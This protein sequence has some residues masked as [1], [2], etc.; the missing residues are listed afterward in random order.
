MAKEIVTL[1]IEDTCL[2]LMVV[3]DK[4]VRLAVSQPLEAG[5][6]KNGTVVDRQKLSQAIGD[7]FQSHG[8]ANGKVVMAISGINAFYRLISQPPVPSDMLAEAAKREA[9]R[10]MPVPLSE[11]HLSYQVLSSSKIES[12]LGL[13]GLPR[14]PT[15]AQVETLRM[16]GLNPYVMDI[17]PLALVRAVSEPEAIFIEVQEATFDIVLTVDGLPQIIRSLSFPRSSLPWPEKVTAITEELDR[18]VKFYNSAHKDRPLKTTVALFVSGEID[19]QGEEL[20]RQRLGYESRALPEPPF[21]VD[22]LDLRRYLVNLGLALKVADR[23]NHG[24]VNINVLPEKYLPKKRPLAQ[25]LAVA[26]LPLALAGSIGVNML[27][28]N[29]RDDTRALEAK[30]AQTQEAVQTRQQETAQ[31]IE[32]E[33]K[34]AA[35]A[36]L[37]ESW[38]RVLADLK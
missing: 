21:A 35:L 25:V 6:V 27:V 8:V 7:L 36:P 9:E 31:F 13:V 16:A 34:T 33:Q 11:L 28:D 2:R 38:Q 23:T 37:A 18:T 22:G 26:F 30:L 5:L 17:K 20:L 1:N 29:A 4:E 12:V 24:G 19:G 3:K 15:E 32:L 14:I 10:V